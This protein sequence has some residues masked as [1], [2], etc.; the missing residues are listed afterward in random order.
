MGQVHILHVFGPIHHH[1]FTIINFITVS[2][3]PSQWGRNSSTNWGTLYDNKP[4]II[5]SNKLFKKLTI[6]LKTY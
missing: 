3:I 1:V 2:T 4:T 6:Q 5:F